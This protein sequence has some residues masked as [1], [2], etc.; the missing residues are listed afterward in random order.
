M[1]RWV[2]PLVCCLHVACASHQQPKGTK[3]AT[4]AIRDGVARLSDALHDCHERHKVGG[5]VQ[6]KMTIQH[7]GRVSAVELDDRFAGTP[8]GECVRQVLLDQ[9]RFD[10][11][12]GPIIIRY[13][14]LLR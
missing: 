14:L 13:P 5:Y 2:V 6:A 10:V 7:S 8:A 4:S 11:D 9:A 12:H 1:K 3:E